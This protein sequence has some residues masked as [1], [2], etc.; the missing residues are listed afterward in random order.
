MTTTFAGLVPRADFDD[1]E[2]RIRDLELGVRLGYENP[3]D[4]RKL[5]RRLHDAGHLPGVFSVATVAKPK[6][7]GNLPPV[8]ATEYWL[9]ERS[10]LFVV[11]KAGTAVADAVLAEVVDVFVRYRRGELVEP[12]IAAPRVTH[13]LLSENPCDWDPM[14]ERM[15]VDG[16]CAI[17]GKPMPANGAQPQWLASSYAK[18]YRMTLGKAEYAELKLRNGEPRFGS[19]HHQFLKPGPRDRFRRELKTV[20]GFLRASLAT[21]SPRQHFW[22]LMSFH[23]EDQ[24]SIQMWMAV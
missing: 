1:K 17:H 19:N 18:I 6:N 8:K 15:I 14:F 7:T 21:P 23:Y 4:V 2:P 5:V 22:N 12:A 3:I 9:D 16:F 20:V 24:G 13:L 10:A 11:A